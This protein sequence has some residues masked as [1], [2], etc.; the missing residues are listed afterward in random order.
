MDIRF[1]GQWFQ[2]ETG[3]AY[4]WHRHYD[5]TTGRYVQPDPLLS[6]DG[7]TFIRGLLAISV[8]SSSAISLSDNYTKSTV[9]LI[10]NSKMMPEIYP[11][12]PIAPTGSSLYAYARQT[13]LTKRDRTGLASGPYTPLQRPLLPVIDCLADTFELTKIQKLG[14]GLYMCL[15]DQVGRKTIEKTTAIEK[16]THQ[17]LDQVMA[18]DPSECEESHIGRK[19]R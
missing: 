18:F 2:L 12:P 6:D 11:C 9:G 3:L 7:E 1:P 16:T 17:S 13:P 8:R 14:G 19:M 4:N 10:E 15:V 5:A